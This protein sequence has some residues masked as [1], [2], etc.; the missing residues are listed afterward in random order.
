LNDVQAPP[1]QLDEILTLPPDPQPDTSTFLIA[2]R[3]ADV[4]RQQEFRR[5]VQLFRQ[6]AAAGY[7]DGDSVR[8]RTL[9]AVADA[10]EGYATWRR[11]DAA[12]AWPALESA[13]K[14]V[15]WNRENAWIRSWLAQIAAELGRPEEAIRY[16]ES[17]RGPLGSR[18]LYRLARAYEAAGRRDDA[19]RTYE[20]VLIAWSDADPTMAPRVAE[21]RQ[22]LAGLGIAPRG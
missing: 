22:R 13:Q 18:A 4:G 5:G 20:L 21:V 10:L 6:T 2:A 17:L 9:E 3:A 1:G 11:G 8:A 15:L 14:R 19:R 12:A 7:A 16:L